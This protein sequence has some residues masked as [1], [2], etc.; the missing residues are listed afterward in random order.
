MLTE[1]IKKGIK[2]TYPFHMPGHKRNYKYLKN[3]APLDVTEI[4]TTDNLHSPL[5][6]IKSA[7]DN[8]T[9]VFGSKKTFYI[10]GGS[11]TA[12]FAAIKSVTKKGDQI[13]IA[14]NCHKSVWSAAEVLNLKTDYV[15]PKIN[16]NLGV[17]GEVAPE[18]IEKLLSEKPYS[19]VVITSPTYEGIVSDISSIAKIVHKFGAVLI[20][21][22]AHGAHLG[23]SEDFPKSARHLD[24]DIVIESAHKTLPCL[25][26]SAML[27]IC[28]DSIDET[29]VS[30]AISTFMTSSPPYPII[31][32]L[33]DMTHLL[34]KKGAKLFKNYSALL[35]NF[36]KRCESLKNLF[37]FKGEEA[38]SFDKGK[39]LILTKKA[40][41]N[42]FKL[43]EMLLKKKIATEMAE[44]ELCLCMTSI[45]DTK[46]GF[47]KLFSALKKIDKTLLTEEKETKV[48]YSLPRREIY[49]YEAKGKESVYIIP[50][51]SEGK[52]ASEYIFA[53]PPGCPIIAPGEI[54]T[55][56]VLC[57]IDFLE[58]SGANIHSSSGK[59]PE[60][61][62]ISL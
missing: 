43:K 7:L 51:E 5:G 35:D 58:K 25:T 49:P 20:V 45:A 13:I 27:H 12:I 17:F 62:K 30:E 39:I 47:D 59:Y 42:G 3:Y 34:D 4:E 56:E 38:F 26:G 14:R 9:R 57:Y 55:K 28:S 23:F 24:A 21:D 32:S 8:T 44:N 22:A 40:N 19:A 18:S 11:T 48:S 6:A 31:Y 36:Y 29:R 37:L 50:S 46:K 1:K 60:N 15:C 61:I 52:I 10:T 41:I 2:G 53:Y 16:L 33:D 54:I